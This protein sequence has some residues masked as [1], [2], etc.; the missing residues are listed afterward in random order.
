M[1]YH[2]DDGTS[3]YTRI[4]ATPEE[5]SECLRLELDLVRE[6]KAARCPAFRPSG[7]HA[8]ELLE[9][10]G[11]DRLKAGKRKTYRRD[12]VTIRDMTRL[13]P[14]RRDDNADTVAKIEG[15][16]DVASFENWGHD[17][18]EP[19]TMRD[20]F[21]RAGASPDAIESL[22]AEA[23]RLKAQHAAQKFLLMVEAIGDTDAGRVIL[24]AIGRPRG[25]LTENAKRS[26][27]SK[28]AFSK[29]A[30]HLRALLN[31]AA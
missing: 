28:Q 12:A 4:Y 30:K 29:R 17:R 8:G 2:T 18:N 27:C 7:I 5:A 16:L 22:V 10:L 24:Y 21:E 26:G 3:I 15:A 1:T 11:T 6:A 14:P 31:S 19:E 23:E 13:E 20:L 25:S 9:W